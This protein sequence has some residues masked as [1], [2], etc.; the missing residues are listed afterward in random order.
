VYLAT[1]QAFQR[2]ARHF[3]DLMGSEVRSPHV[4]SI[5]VRLLLTNGR[6]GA[7]EWIRDAVT[8]G[9]SYCAR[10]FVGRE[11]DHLWTPWLLH[12]GLSPDHATGGMMIPALAATLHGHG[13]PV[14]AGGADT[15]LTAFRRL[16]DELGVQVFT[17]TSAERVV[18]DTGRAVAVEAGRHRYQARRAILAAVAPTALYG[19]LLPAEASSPTMR[20]QAASYRYGR[21]GMQIHVALSSPLRW[22]DSRLNDVPLIHVT[23]GSPTTAIACAEADAGLLPRRPTIVV[24]QQALLDPTRVPAGAGALWLQLQEVPFEPRGDALGVLDAAQGWTDVLAQAYAQRALDR[25]GEHAHDIATQALAMEVL[26]P[27]I[28]QL[29]N[30]NAVDGDPYGGSA[31]LDQKFFWRPFP[32]AARHRTHIKGL[33][34]IGASTH[35]GPGLGAGS[36]H[37]VAA[38]LIGRRRRNLM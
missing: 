13:L 24:G 3:A 2:S 6:A 30:V 15:I 23:D 35:P 27:P 8:S 20:K 4:F 28:L 34:H 18:I 11:V 7:E 33:W 36:G 21:A 32:R 5:L 38:E 17:E 14:V 10:T 22:H 29:D 12:A 9:R 37:L 26:S 19:S 31:E 1:L 16:F 25:I